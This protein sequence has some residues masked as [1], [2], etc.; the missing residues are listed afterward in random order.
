MLK[1][2]C[3]LLLYGLRVNDWCME[4]IQKIYLEVVFQ[5]SDLTTQPG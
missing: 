5:L 3:L 2:K 1:Y 4:E